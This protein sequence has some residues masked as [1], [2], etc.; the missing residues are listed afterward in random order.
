MYLRIFSSLQNENTKDFYHLFSTREIWN[1]ILHHKQKR[2]THIYI[3]PH[4]THSDIWRKH[5]ESTVIDKLIYQGWIQNLG[6][7]QGSLSGFPTM[8]STTELLSYK[9]HVFQLNQ[10]TLRL[11]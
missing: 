10:G 9:N 2:T 3:Y 8:V 1:I 11:V 7:G 6:V 4:F 5:Q